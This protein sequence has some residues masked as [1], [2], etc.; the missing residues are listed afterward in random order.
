[1]VTDLRAVVLFLIRRH[2]EALQPGGGFDQFCRT[3][4]LVNREVER[5]LQAKDAYEQ[6]RSVP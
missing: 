1:M 6:Q 4:K 2:L 5:E 3:E